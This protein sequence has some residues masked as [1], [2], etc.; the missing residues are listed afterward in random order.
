MASRRILITGLS[1][2]WGGRLAQALE[3]VPEVEAVIGVDRRP[4][5]LELART[6]FVRVSDSHSLIR[7]IVEGAEIDTVV[8]TRLVVDS[9]VTTPRLAHENNVIGTMNVLAACGG[10]DSP[11]RKVVFRSS[12]HVYG[13][14]QDDPAFFTEDMHP[15]HRPGTALEKGI[16]DAERSVED[17]AARHPDKVVTS[18]RFA[19]GLGPSLRTSVTELL[20]LPVVPMILGFDPR[21]QFVHEDDI[22]GV[23]EH[24]VRHD[25][26]GAYNVAGDGVLALSEAISLLGKAP[27]PVLPPWG[28][29][30]AV[31]A[32]GRAGIARIPPELLKLLR[33]GRGVDNRRL[34]AAGYRFR[35]TTRETVLKLGEHQRLAP[36]KDASAPVY[37]YEEEV[38]EF[39]RWSPSVR[40]HPDDRGG[41]AGRPT[42]RQLAELR[43]VIAALEGE[44][45]QVNVAPGGAEQPAPLPS[46]PEPRFADL[47][48]RE[49]IEV[50]P[51]LERP[52]LEALR[53]H[54]REHAGRRT[55]LAAIDALLGQD[56]ESG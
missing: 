53:E 30:L 23:L 40:R 10:P 11:V 19:Q 27:A 21:M 18:L 55:V 48:A 28:T 4:P 6:E 17:F 33:F 24:A 7:R 38:E 15:F 5:K 46:P 50:L 43:R 45:G 42:P 47:T 34:K 8:D 9:I 16:V 36:F 56:A 32:L 26:P 49:L 20:G 1:T 44:G 39:L 31:A 22:V 54:E 14:E 12:T 13:A 41:I 3:G 52:G 35:Y 25:L 2:Y 51:S 37:R 29:G